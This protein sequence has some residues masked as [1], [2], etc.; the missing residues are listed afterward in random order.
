[1]NADRLPDLEPAI[2]ALPPGEF[3]FSTIYGDDWNDLY[4]GDK[5]ELGRAFMRLV[6][7]G[8]FPKVTD[9][10]RKTGAGRVYLKSR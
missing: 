2:H 7:Q 4:V 9:T 10:G 5:V 8:R 6:R 1:M 3:H